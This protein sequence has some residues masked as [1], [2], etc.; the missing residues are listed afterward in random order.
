MV[1][2][3][4]VALLVRV[5]VLGLLH[6]AEAW[7]EG[8]GPR[9]AVAEG[10]AVRLDG[11]AAVPAVRLGGHDPGAP[12]LL[13]RV[14]RLPAPRAFEGVL[15]LTARR[16]TLLVV[17]ELPLE[18][19]VAGV[20]AAELSPDAPAA[21]AEALAIAARSFA[22]RRTEEGAVHA[23]GAALCDQ[24]HCQVFA[25][26]APAAARAAVARTEGE[27]LLL[28]SGR[29]APALHH[30]ACGGRTADARDVWPAAGG[31][32]AEEIGRAHV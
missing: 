4:L 30:A 28:A 25:G 17:N 31:D 29:V 21:A 32:E 18:A 9:H 10:D 13:V 12:P 23:A 7:I 15:L 14:P 22:V 11:A 20:V 5:E 16:G 6:P 2:G 27:V 8:P 1:L 26:R 24:T 3:L 19:Y